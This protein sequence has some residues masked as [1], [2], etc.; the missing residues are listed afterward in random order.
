M[1]I[2]SYPKV[3]AIGREAI[4]GIF[5]GEVIVEEKVDGSQFSFCLGTDGVLSM[6]SKGA[7]IDEH[8]KDKLFRG[9]VD[10]VLKL[11]AEARLQPNGWVYRGEVLCKPKHNS[12][13]YERVPLNNIIIYDIDTGGEHYLDSATRRLQAAH[14]SLETVPVLHRGRILVVDELMALLDNVSCLGGS[15]VEG[16]V[17]KR[18]D[19]FTRDGKIAVGKYVSE[20]FKEVHAGDWKKRNPTRADI[21]DRLIEQHRTEARWQKAVQHLRDAGKLEGEPRDIGALVNEAQADI[22]HECGEEISAALWQHFWPQIKRGVVRGLPEWYKT[23]L[24]KGAFS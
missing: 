23:E 13:C 19:M 3:Y 17:V 10:T 20:A 16:V 5:D 2:S 15:K 22:A 7:M 21:V 24:A 8:T 1:H 9:A 12:L 11:V 14:L 18:Y 4:D 6:R